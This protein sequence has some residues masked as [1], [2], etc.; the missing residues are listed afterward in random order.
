LEEELFSGKKGDFEKES[1]FRKSIELS[2]LEQ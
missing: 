1:N 2:E